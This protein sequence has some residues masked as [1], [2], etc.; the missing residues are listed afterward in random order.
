MLRI[1]TWNIERPKRS[2]ATRRDRL[3]KAIQTVQADIWILT[4]THTSISPGLD[5]TSV[6]T[7]QADRAQEPGESWVAIWS[8]FPM[9][10]AAST[11]D[12][13]REIAHR[14]W[15][16]VRQSLA[17]DSCGGRRAAFSAALSTQLADWLS[18]HQNSPDCDFIVAGDFGV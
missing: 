8:R 18:L 12:S 10:S 15:H 17:R 13:C 3:L 5:F 4:E 11:S 14:L 7:Q 1:A 2:E 9:E 6:S 16:L